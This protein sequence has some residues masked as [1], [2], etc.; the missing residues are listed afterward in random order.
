M[1]FY[2]H[3]STCIYVCIFLFSKGNIKMAYLV[4]LLIISSYLEVNKPV[5]T[6][7]QCIQILKDQVLSL[8]KQYIN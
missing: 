7:V 1:H 8:R 6:L 3:I 4:N 2:I 5:K